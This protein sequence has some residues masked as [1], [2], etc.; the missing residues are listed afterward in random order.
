KL[1]NERVREL[2]QRAA[3]RLAQAHASEVLKALASG[4]PAAQLEMVRVAGRLKLPGAPDG[5]GR[6]LEVGD[7]GLKV[8]VVEALTA[9]ATPSAMRVL[10]KAVDDGE[11]D[12]R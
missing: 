2:V 8:A 6:L 10:E 9:I 7:R 3:E 11:R 4:D 1:T 5:M 12:V